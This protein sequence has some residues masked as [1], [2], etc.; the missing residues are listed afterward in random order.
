MGGRTGR[1]L[2]I[3]VANEDGLI[4]HTVAQ[5]QLYVNCAGRTIQ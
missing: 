1:Y 5:I 4:S 3:N 2:K